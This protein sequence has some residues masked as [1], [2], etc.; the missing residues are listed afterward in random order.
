MTE[1]T[2][3]GFATYSMRTSQHACLSTSTA[4]GR[5]ENHCSARWWCWR[6]MV[7]VGTT[8]DA[9]RTAQGSGEREGAG[10]ARQRSSGVR[11][12]PTLEPT[13]GEAELFAQQRG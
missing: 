12:T 6:A 3:I 4:L 13:A 5:P 7:C 10:C 8:A 1:A 11:G 2:R 9:L